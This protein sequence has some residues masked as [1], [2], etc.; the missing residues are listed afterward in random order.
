M[1]R[2]VT[3]GD[4]S[5]PPGHLNRIEAFVDEQSPHPSLRKRQKLKELIMVDFPPARSSLTS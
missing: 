4:S 1:M 5:R 2:D 3:K